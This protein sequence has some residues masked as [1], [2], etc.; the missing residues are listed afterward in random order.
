[1]LSWLEVPLIVGD[2]RRPL[3]RDRD[4]A[5]GAVRLPPGHPADLGG[6]HPGHLLRLADHHPDRHRPGAPQPDLLHIYMLNPLAVIFQQFRHAF[7]THATPSAAALL[8][9]TA[10]LLEPVAIMVAIFVVG[11]WVFNRI[12]PRVAEDL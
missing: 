2:A 3:H 10:A 9:S 1:M 11:F 7:I 5:V 12:A 6:A 4:A 8:G